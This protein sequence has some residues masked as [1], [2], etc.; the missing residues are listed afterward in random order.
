MNSFQLPGCSAAQLLAL[1]SEIKASLEIKATDQ[2]QRNRTSPELFIYQADLKALYSA[3][4]QASQWLWIKKKF[5]SHLHN[6]LSSSLRDNMASGLEEDLSCQICH[7]VFRDPVFLSCSH[8][9]C[10]DCLKSCWRQ[11]L[12]CECPLCK[13]RSSQAEPP[14]NLVLKNLCESF[15]QDRDQRASEALCSLHSD[16]VKLKHCTVIPRRK[17]STAIGCGTGAV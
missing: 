15:L 7:D 5:T 10:K 4:E 1:I 11:K 9:F 14:R 6:G 3:A 12:T 13:R 17:R 8:S 2:S 16:K